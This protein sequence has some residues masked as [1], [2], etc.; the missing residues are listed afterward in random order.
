MTHGQ[1]QKYIG[2]ELTIILLGN[3]GHKMT[4]TEK[5]VT[6]QQKPN[7]IECVK[8]R[9]FHYENMSVMSPQLLNIQYW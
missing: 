1:F 4:V 9:Q 7:Q 3:I 5:Y 8:S 2:D 6:N